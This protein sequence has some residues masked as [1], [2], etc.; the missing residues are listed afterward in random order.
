MKK[1]RR[2]KKKE[3][4]LTRIRSDDHI[5]TSPVPLVY[6]HRTNLHCVISVLIYSPLQTLRTHNMYSQS[7]TKVVKDNWCHLLTFNISTYTM[8]YTLHLLIKLQYKSN[9]FEF[10]L[11]SQQSI[12]D[13]QLNRQRRKKTFKTYFH[14]F[15][16]KLWKV[17]KLVCNSLISFVNKKTSKKRVNDSILYW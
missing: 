10:M 6:H 4:D 2:E 3:A 17:Y 12:S 1:K 7:E 15:R 13:K 9:T 11:L 5:R 16:S 14:T 8:G